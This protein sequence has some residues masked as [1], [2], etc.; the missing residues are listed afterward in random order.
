MKKSELTHVEFIGNG[1]FAMVDKYTNNRGDLFA[2]KS[3]N[4]DPK[5]KSIEDNA[6]QRFIK[7]ARFQQGIDHPNIVKILDVQIQ[8]DPPYYIMP[9]AS[10][11]LLDEINRK[12]IDEH[13]FSKC[14]YDIMAGLEEMHSLGIYHRDL[15]PGNVLKFNDSYAIGD[16]GLMSFKQT[17]LTTLT[18]AG[19]RKGSDFYTAPEITADLRRASIQSD[20]YSLGCMLH[21]FVGESERF[22]CSVIS[23]SSKY[24]S[25]L[26]SATRREPNRRFPNVA[27]FREALDSVMQENDVTVKT[28]QAERVLETLNMDIDTYSKKEISMLADF[29]SSTVNNSEKHSVMQELKINHIKKIN[30]FPESS[31]YI[32]KVYCEYVGDSSFPWDFCDTLANR[33]IIFIENG[34]IDVKSEG[35]LALVYMG[36]DH[37]R[38]YVERKAAN[39]LSGDIDERLLKRLIIE[40][41]I[42]G[43][44][45][46]HTIYRMCR[47]I[48]ISIDTF[49]KDIVKAI[50]S[51]KYE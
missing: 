27:S 48:N 34:D 2:I 51:I 40:I 26:L 32:A 38:W 50:K 10:S 5:M 1:G 46:S 43:E 31:S 16:F 19:M 4:I 44:K 21:D 24:A 42:D 47:S 36:A 37:N 35:I 30:Q 13:N 9:V 45:F 3:F 17:N 28:K 22:P 29:L 8:E 25:I 12:S 23:E 33:L 14:F 11:S 49:N 6:R 15:K 41:K 7:E 20:I 39:Y 18:T